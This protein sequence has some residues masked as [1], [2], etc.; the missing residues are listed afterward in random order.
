M[1]AIKIRKTVIQDIPRIVFETKTIHVAEVQPTVVQDVVSLYNSNKDFI[2]H[3]MGTDHITPEWV[4]NEWET[5]KQSGFL[6]CKAMDKK[7]GNTIG[8]IDFKVGE[9]TYLSLL[10]IHEEAQN[11][12][13]GK[14]IYDAFEEYATAAHSKSIRLDVVTKYSDNVAKFWVKRGFVKERDIELNWSGVI[15]PAVVMKKALC[16]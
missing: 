1:G 5:M 14:Q 9:E 13:I 15:L 4:M 8:I 3:H 2:R 12:G 7:S 6:S 11:Q 10:T 16:E